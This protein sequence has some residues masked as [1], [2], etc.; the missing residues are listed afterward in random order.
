M[1]NHFGLKDFIL[2]VLVIGVGVLVLLKMHQDDRTFLELRQISDTLDLQSNTLGRLQRTLDRGLTVNTVPLPNGSMATSG[3]TSTRDESWAQ[4]GI[5]VEWPEPWGPVS[6]PT[7][8]DDFAQSP[9]AADLQNR[10][11]CRTVAGNVR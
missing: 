4:P 11:P 5:P 1:E 3:T 7:Q 2:M 8:F 10:T 9:C 6:D